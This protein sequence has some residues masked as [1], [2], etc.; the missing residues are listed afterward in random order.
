MRL[1]ARYL[2]ELFNGQARGNDR[3][4]G[5]LLLVFPFEGGDAARCNYISNAGREDMVRLMKEM[6]ARFE[7]DEVPPDNL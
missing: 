2:D 6:V 1:L 4:V 3:E 5:F 7:A